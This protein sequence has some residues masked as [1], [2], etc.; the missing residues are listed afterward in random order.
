MNP[1]WRRRIASL[2]V[3]ESLPSTNEALL[4]AASPPPAGRIA[5]CL[6]HHQSAGKGRGGKQWHSP[7]GAGLLLSVSRSAPH[8]PDSSLALALGVSAAEALEAFAAVDIR[9]KWPNDL[10]ADNGKLGGILV[11]SASR[12][13]AETLIVAGLGV[14]LR[15]SDEQRRQVAEEGGMAPSALEDWPARGPLDRHKLAADMIAAFAGV[16]ETHPV[17]GFRPWEESWRLRD[18]LRG[19]SIEARC[20]N[21]AHRGEAAGVDSSGA[22]LLNEPGG[23]RRRIL[24]AEIRL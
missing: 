14:N 4:N 7:P 22:L 18:W 11:E 5:A 12:T 8:P 15:V 6:A 16:L 19:R 3:H 13:G 21:Q 10:I 24:S 2:D 9:L 23:E 17:Q 20:G 1:K